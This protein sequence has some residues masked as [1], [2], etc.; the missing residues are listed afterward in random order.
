MNCSEV[1]LPVHFGRFFRPLPKELPP[2]LNALLAV[3]AIALWIVMF[4]YWEMDKSV[5]TQTLLIGAGVVI[6]I[7]CLIYIP[8]RVLLGLAIGA[9]G[10]LIVYEAKGM[11]DWQILAGLIVIGFGWV[12][13][14]IDKGAN[15]IL[16]RL[17]TLEEKLV[18]IESKQDCL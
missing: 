12:T 9:V 1:V 13:W 3:L 7:G 17:D 10:T 8:P 6:A 14:C 16:R 11:K 2:R 5:S 15:L 18:E 4:R